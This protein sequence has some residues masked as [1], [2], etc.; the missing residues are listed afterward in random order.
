MAAF[1]DEAI[2]LRRLDYSES[3]QVLAFFM[4]EHGQQRLIAKGIKRSTKSRFMP[5][6][7][8]L[9]RGH[10]TFILSSRT[11]GGLGTLTEWHQ[12]DAYLGLR[13][14]LTRLY[15]AQYGAEIT[16]AMTEENDPHAEVF[17]ALAALFEALAGGESALGSLA[18]YQIALIHAVGLWPDLTRCVMCDRVAPPQRAAYFSARQ[19]GVVCRQCQSRAGQTRLVNAAALMALREGSI[20]LDLARPVLELLD[21]T[22]VCHVGR[23]TSLGAF[24]K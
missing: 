7:D 17:D 15:A 10:A 23:P 6:I 20:S 18:A 4:R 24:V 1:K 2:V 14:D 5:A 12:T 22:I 16:S 11:E 9:E 19:G 21:H 8:L 3:S 13:E